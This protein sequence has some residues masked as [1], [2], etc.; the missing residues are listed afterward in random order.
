MCFSFFFENYRFL[1]YMEA[2]TGIFYTTVL[3]ASLIGMRL[4]QHTDTMARRSAEQEGLR[5]DDGSG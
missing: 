2:I 1:A 4:A 3:V 5:S